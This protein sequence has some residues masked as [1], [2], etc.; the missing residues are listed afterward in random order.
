M[1][2]KT[3]ISENNLSLCAGYLGNTLLGLRLTPDM[4]TH[5][6]LNLLLDCQV[7][8]L[9]PVEE[10]LESNDGVD[11]TAADVGE[12]DNVVPGLLNTG[13]DP[14]N[15]SQAQQEAGDSGQLACVTIAEVGD[16][17]DHFS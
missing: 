17:L 3:K 1:L 4:S 16:D 10:N 15:S 12:D 8:C 5:N 11:D 2:N 14:G 6:L 7:R 13:E 9:V